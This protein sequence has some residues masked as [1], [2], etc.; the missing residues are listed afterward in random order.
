MDAVNELSCE[1]AAT[2][3]ARIKTNEK[4]TP[5]DAVNLI[6]NFYNALSPLQEQSDRAS[7]EKMFP[8]E[9]PLKEK[10]ANGNH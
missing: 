2:V 7:R 6:R 5:Q 4:L 3:F 10:A 8:K 9:I 1:F